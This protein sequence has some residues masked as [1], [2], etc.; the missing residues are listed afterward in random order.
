MEIDSTRYG[1]GNKGKQLA[2]RDKILTAIKAAELG[3]KDITIPKIEAI[4]ENYEIDHAG[5]GKVLY[6]DQFQYIA[7]EF[8]QAINKANETIL[9]AERVDKNAYILSFVNDMKAKKKENGGSYTQT[10]LDKNIQDNWK[11]DKYGKPPTEVIG[12]VT[13]EVKEDSLTVP[14]LKHQW[15]HG[16]LTEDMVYMLNDAEDR[17]TWLA[18]VK[19]LSPNAAI[20]STELTA[21]KDAAVGYA[22][23]Q[24]KLTGGKGTLL[25]EVE[26]N[27]RQNAEWYYPGL[28]SHHFNEGANS[29][30]DAI[31]AARE[32]MKK[33][34]ING[35][36]D[37]L[38]APST[39]VNERKRNLAMAQGHLKYDKD[40]INTGILA[41]S[42]SI[43]DSAEKLHKRNIAHPF[44]VQLAKTIKVNGKPVHPLKIQANQL[45]VKGKLEDT[46]EPVKSVVLEAWEKLPET[47]KELLSVHTSPAA[48]ARGKIE[49]FFTDG[50]WN[51]ETMSFGE[52]DGVINYSDPSISKLAD[53]VLKNEDGKYDDFFGYGD[54]DE[55]FSKEEIVF[56][57]KKLKRLSKRQLMRRNMSKYRT[58]DG[59]AAEKFKEFI[60]SGLQFPGLFLEDIFMKEKL[61]LED[62]G[63][64]IEKREEEVK[65]QRNRFPKKNRRRY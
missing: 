19:E 34:V 3:D 55:K 21:G 25:K 2:A 50:K 5:S 35:D 23:D 62:I 1:D 36:W 37:K 39:D 8:R 61:I 14:Y 46:G 54:G 58:D 51:K 16:L 42:E 45:A 59:E 60:K 38:V 65:E 30:Q 18:R 6:V 49:A 20:D 7:T 40:V 47:T 22:I 24:S 32:E 29:M 11:F 13:D 31:I 56:E 52:G 15:D 4:L 64:L 57:P 48:L 9:N 43:L 12:F 53:E 33:K 26:N 27:I 63:D 41:G 10:D 17:K 28:V 44:Y